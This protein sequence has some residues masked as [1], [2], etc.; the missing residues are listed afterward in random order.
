MGHPWEWAGLQQIVEREAWIDCELLSPLVASE[1]A[2]QFWVL[3]ILWIFEEPVKEAIIAWVKGL[4]LQSEGSER[5][6]PLMQLTNNW[7]L[8]KNWV[9]WSPI[10]LHI[11]VDKARA[12]DSALIIE[13]EFYKD[14]VMNYVT[15][16]RLR[17]SDTICIGY[18]DTHFLKRNPT[19][20][21]YP[22][23][24]ICLSNEY[25]IRIHHPPWSI[26]V[27]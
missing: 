6:S 21:V 1:W 18:A 23:I 15:Q 11:K 27:T 10:L 25:Q 20:M 5:L 16:V 22:S 3:G 7:Q 2:I 4:M 24:R 12:A 26:H 17:V 19:K 14:V 13:D 8:V 9:L